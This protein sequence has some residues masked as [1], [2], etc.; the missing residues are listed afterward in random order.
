[1]ICAP[2]V[3]LITSDGSFKTKAITL[4]SIHVLLYLLP[5][6]FVQFRRVCLAKLQNLK[7]KCQNKPYKAPPPDPHL[8]LPLEERI[9]GRINNAIPFRHFHPRR[10]IHIHL[11]KRHIPSLARLL[12]RPP[13]LLLLRDPFKRLLY[14]IGNDSTLAREQR[15]RQGMGMQ[16]R[17]E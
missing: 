16:R 7:P 6:S 2:W 12:A 1:M 5:D 17:R 10:H 14:L 11:D 3:Q 15:K 8:F 9:P 13:A 4:G